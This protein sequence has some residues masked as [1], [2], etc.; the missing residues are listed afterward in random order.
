MLCGSGGSYCNAAISTPAPTGCWGI[1]KDRNGWN[2]HIN[3]LGTG[4]TV[5]HGF[6]HYP[7]IHS[8]SCFY[9]SSVNGDVFGIR[10]IYA[11]SCISYANFGY[12]KNPP[13]YG[14]EASSQCEFCFCNGTSGGQ[15]CAASTSFGAQT[16]SLQ[17][18]GAGGFAS[19]NAGGCIQRCGDSGRMGMVCVS[20]K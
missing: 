18:P 11:E 2:C 13:V 19:Q 9:G 14:F 17:I 5:G 7:A 3:C 8:Q 4:F 15:D 1:D 6:I 10:G 12:T 20:Y 16:V